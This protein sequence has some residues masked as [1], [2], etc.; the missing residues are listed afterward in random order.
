MSRNHISEGLQ[1]DILGWFHV[2]Q[3]EGHQFVR[4]AA[5]LGHFGSADVGVVGTECALHNGV[6][7]GVVSLVTRPWTLSHAQVH[8]KC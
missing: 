4:D 1:D 2:Q 5:R 6:V 8:L 3:G 7:G